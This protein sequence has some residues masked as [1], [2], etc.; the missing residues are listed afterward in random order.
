MGVSFIT[1]IVENKIPLMVVGA[2][3]SYVAKILYADYQ[4]ELALNRIKRSEII[5]AGKEFWNEVDIDGLSLLSE[6]EARTEI[7]KRYEKQNCAARKFQA[8][9]EDQSEF[10]TAWDEF[11]KFRSRTFNVKAIQSHLKKFRKFTNPA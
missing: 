4:H 5:E 2:M 9:L 3:F 1:L 7:I 10:S 6:S 11:V 8:T